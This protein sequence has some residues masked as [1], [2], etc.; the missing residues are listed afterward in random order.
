MKLLFTVN[1]LSYSD[2]V[3]KGA[4]MGDQSDSKDPLE[5]KPEVDRKSAGI[6]P[7]VGPFVSTI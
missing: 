4:N 3:C 7:E 2:F 6:E 5:L 1:N